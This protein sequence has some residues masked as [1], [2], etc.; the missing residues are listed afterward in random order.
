VVRLRDVLAHV[1]DRVPLSTSD[2]GWSSFEG[3]AKREKTPVRKS[4]KLGSIQET[5]ESF[6]PAARWMNVEP[7]YG[8][9]RC[10]SNQPTRSSR[11]F[12]S[13]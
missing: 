13:G 7:K 1:R 8:G 4:A 3:G 2:G 12:W 9:R 6:L 10:P 5:F 11:M